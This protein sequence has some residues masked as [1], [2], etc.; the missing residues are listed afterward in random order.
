[1]QFMIYPSISWR[2]FPFDLRGVLNGKWDTFPNDSPDMN[3]EMNHLFEFSANQNAKK[4][5]NFTN[6]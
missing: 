1:M 2:S 4:V 6:G 3:E 5:K